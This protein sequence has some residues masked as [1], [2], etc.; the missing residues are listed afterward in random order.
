M[1]RCSHGHEFRT[2]RLLLV[3]APDGSDKVGHVGSRSR[4]GSP[5]NTFLVK[6]PAEEA[7]LIV[8]MGVPVPADL[9]GIETAS[10]QQG[11]TGGGGV[12]LCFFALILYDC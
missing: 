11:S 9:S 1:L 3:R 12:C 7:A 8:V 5:G 10:D 4:R 6:M 2:V